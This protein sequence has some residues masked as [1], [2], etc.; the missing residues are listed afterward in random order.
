MVAS[1]LNVEFYYTERHVAPRPEAL[2]PMEYRLSTGLRKAIAGK[3]VA[4]IDDAINAGS[5]VRG[6][7]LEVQTKGAKVAAFGTPP[8][9]GT[10]FPRLVTDQGIP[11]G[12]PAALSRN[13]LRPT[14]WPVVQAQ[15]P[16]DNLVV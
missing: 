11:L 12:R 8:V 14:G 2:Y 16:L 3:T 9:L 5:A 13:L 10:G 7:L 4:I 1:E 6:T 15:T